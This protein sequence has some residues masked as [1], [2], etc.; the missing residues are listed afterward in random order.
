VAV[1]FFLALL[2]MVNTFYVFDPDCKTPRVARAQGHW[3]TAVPQTANTMTI[4]TLHRQRS[5]FLKAGDYFSVNG[6]LKM[7][8]T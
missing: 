3:S 6:E 8:R 7:Q 5:L 1:R 4:G 2:G